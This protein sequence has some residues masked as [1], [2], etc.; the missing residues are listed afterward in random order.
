MTGEVNLRG[1]V[2]IWGLKEKLLAARRWYK[3]R[4]NP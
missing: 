1:E 3:D 4:L 2:P